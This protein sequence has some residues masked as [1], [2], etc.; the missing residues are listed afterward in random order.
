MD[1]AE[2][3]TAALLPRES[4]P[5]LDVGEEDTSAS[6]PREG[7]AEVAGPEEVDIRPAGEEAKARAAVEEPPAVEVEP[8]AQHTATDVRDIEVPE[9]PS[10]VGPVEFPAPPEGPGSIF[11]G[12]GVRFG[13]VVPSY[14]RREDFSG[15]LLCGLYYRP[16]REERKVRYEFGMDFASSDSMPGN[17]TVDLILARAAALYYPVEARSFYFLGGGEIHVEQIE[18]SAD[19]LSKGVVG[20]AVDFGAGLTFLEDKVDL[21]AAYSFLIGSDNVPG[22]TFL[23][24]GY[25]F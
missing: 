9:A 24:V 18:D 11:F 19:N 25:S 23:T 15:G 14:G 4:A 21:R 5:Q 20:G 10:E 2:E 7:A 16:A 6:L 8:P 22:A 13:Y 1:V 12:L 3:D 17:A